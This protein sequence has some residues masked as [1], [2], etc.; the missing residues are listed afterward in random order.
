MLTTKGDGGE[1]TIHKLIE[2]YRLPDVDFKYAPEKLQL[3]N[4][5]APRLTLLA[6]AQALSEIPDGETVS[7]VTSMEYVR[8]ALTEGQI[9]R[10][11]QNRWHGSSGKV[12][13]ADL[14]HDIAKSLER[15]KLGL[16][17]APAPGE[18]LPIPEKTMQT[19]LEFDWEREP[20]V[21]L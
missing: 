8:D 19:Q 20:E 10:W 12:K 1:H 3:P 18:Y 16:V 15:L 5:T 2:V 9:E 6:V 17:R 14:W 13:N 4:A 7:I 21:S 11:R